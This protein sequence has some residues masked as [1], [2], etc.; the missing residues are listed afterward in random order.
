[1]RAPRIRPLSGDLTSVLG[2]GG[3]RI[4]V[5]AL[6]LQSGDEGPQPGLGTSEAL[7]ALGIDL[8]QVLALESPSTKA[9][10]YTRVAWSPL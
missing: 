2:A 4:D 10:D 6:P 7:S 5:L 9:G 3:P 1:M 8:P